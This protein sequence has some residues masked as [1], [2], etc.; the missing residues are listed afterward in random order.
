MGCSYGKCDHFTLE[1]DGRQDDCYVTTEFYRC[2]PFYPV[3]SYIATG[4]EER[5]SEKTKFYYHYIF[6]RLLNVQIMEGG[7]DSLG[8]FK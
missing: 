8:E 6:Q 1:R 4:P 3:R 5:V 2:S 7:G